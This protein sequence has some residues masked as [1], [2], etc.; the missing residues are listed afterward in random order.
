MISLK[1]GKPPT[2]FSKAPIHSPVSAGGAPCRS[3]LMTRV[4]RGVWRACLDGAAMYGASYHGWPAIEMLP[5]DGSHGSIA[6]SPGVDRVALPS[7]D[8]RHSF[9]H[10]AN[11][12]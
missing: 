8:W 7:P 6:P 3:G 12:L 1:Y 5:S 4:L 2:C 11:S 10:E 9:R